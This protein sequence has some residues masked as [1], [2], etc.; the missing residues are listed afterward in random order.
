MLPQSILLIIIKILLSKLSIVKD[1]TVNNL[2]V[3]C[4]EL[5]IKLLLIMTVLL[6]TCP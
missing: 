3:V 4:W 6:T 5:W 1:W 2:L